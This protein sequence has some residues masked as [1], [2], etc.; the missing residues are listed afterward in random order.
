[1]AVTRGFVWTGGAALWGWKFAISEHGEKSSITGWMCVEVEG[2]RQ[3]G[4]KRFP[5]ALQ[6]LLSVPAKSS[7]NRAVPTSYGHFCRNGRTDGR[8]G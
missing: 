1:M 8:C 2:Q 4:V 5:E 3:L 7:P 6:G